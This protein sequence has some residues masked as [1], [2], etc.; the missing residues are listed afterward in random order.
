MKSQAIKLLGLCCIFYLIHCI[1]SGH[2]VEK[3]P[4]IN[5]NLLL[6]WTGVVLSIAGA[7]LHSSGAS[8]ARRA[9]TLWVISSVILFIYASLTDQFG[10]L[11]LQ[12]VFFWINLRGLSHW[13]SQG[14]AA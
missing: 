12:A 8:Q 14:A 2:E 5:L 4:E 1:Y 9:Y 6:E 3:V 13:K 11:L 7:W 10:I